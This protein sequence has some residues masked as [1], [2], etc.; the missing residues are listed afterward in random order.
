MTAGESD[1]G[2]K[3]LHLA[4]QT[5]LVASL[6][7]ALALV[8]LQIFSRKLARASLSFT[9]EV[10]RY[11]FVLSTLVGTAIGVRAGTLQ[12]AQLLS[13]R[14]PQMAG[15]LARL[16]TAA[17]LMFFG[18]LT[19]ASLSIPL[20]EYHSNQRTP[21]LGF[22]M[23]IIGSALPATFALATFHALAGLRRRRRRAAPPAS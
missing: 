5:I 22:P 6:L 3:S 11:L 9:E 10:V 1:R 8:L 13:L 23:W 16:S 20:S 18:F 19:I 17:L 12:R 14:W 15:K 21:V 2:G 4:E 7:A